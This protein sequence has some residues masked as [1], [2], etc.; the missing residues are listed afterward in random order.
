MC[1]YVLYSYVTNKNRMHP[2]EEAS[3][4]PLFSYQ[5]Q[6]SWSSGGGTTHPRLNLPAPGLGEWS[7]PPGCAVAA[8]LVCAAEAGGLRPIHALLDLTQLHV[9]FV[10]LS[11]RRSTCS[12][13]RSPSLPSVASPCAVL[14]P[15]LRGRAPDRPP[16][17]SV[18][19]EAGAAAACTW[20]VPRCG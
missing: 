7:T 14:E 18:D 16:L 8:C 12:S 15:S 13:C 5:Q 20:L 2:S 10:P 9:L 19:R 11:L 4:D 3:K 6:R 1:A 17:T